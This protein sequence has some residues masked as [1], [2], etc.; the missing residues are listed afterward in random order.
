[1]KKWICALVLWGMGMVSTLD[2]SQAKQANEFYEYPTGS[3]SVSQVY[4]LLNAHRASL[5]NCHK[6]YLDQIPGAFDSLVLEFTLNPSGRVIR[7][8]NHEGSQAKQ[9][10]LAC[11]KAIIK[12][13]HFPQ[14]EMGLATLR[15]SSDLDLISD[16]QSLKDQPLSRNSVRELHYLPQKL[17]S[18]NLEMY[19]PYYKQCLVSFKQVAQ[20]QLSWQVESS[21]NIT[22]FQANFEPYNESLA[23]CLA[24]VTE[25]Q[26]YPSGFETSPATR[27]IRIK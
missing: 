6:V 11:L 8:Q 25:K 16:E 2:V 22:Q 3:V 27:I 1:M 4:E 20:V 13:L 24:Q 5:R 15:W 19:M 23:Q 14:P 7:F 26:Q 18:A 21:G 12:N 10:G 17:I 9:E